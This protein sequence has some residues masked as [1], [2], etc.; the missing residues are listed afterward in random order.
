VEETLEGRAGEIK[1]YV[2]GLAVYR[3]GQDFD[4]IIDSTVRVEASRLRR[5]LANFYEDEGKHDAII[6]SVPKGG[7]VPSIE[8]HAPAEQSAPPERHRFR[9]GAIVAAGVLL[10]GA[11]VAWRLLSMSAER[12]IP[13]IKEVPLTSLPGTEMFASLSPDGEAA[14][15][16][17]TQDV[18]GESTSIEDPSARVFLVSVK[19]GSPRR[20]TKTDIGT[21][22]APAWS[23]SGDQ[24]ALLAGG[25]SEAF[26]YL[27]SVINGQERKILAV[28]N[29]SPETLSW[30]PDGR[31]IAYSRRETG[32]PYAVRTVSIPERTTRQLTTPPSSVLGDADPAFSPDGRWIVFVRRISDLDGDLYL[33]PAGGGEARRLTTLST[34][35]RGE[36]WMPDSNEIVFAAE[37]AGVYS[38]MRI[39]IDHRGV[40]SGPRPVADIGGYGIYPAVLR[41][42]GGATELT[43]ARIIKSTNIWRADKLTT[44]AKVEFSRIAPSTR[45]DYDPS[46]SPD[47]SSIAFASNR[48]GYF[49]IWVCIKDGSNPRQ[50]TSFGGRD[51]GSPRWS[52]DGRHIVFDAQPGN[53]PDIYVVESDG[54]PV[55]RITSQPSDDARPSWSGDGRW[56]YFRSD[57]GGKRQIWRIRYTGRAEP[58]EHAELVTTGTAHEAFESPDGAWVYFVRQP[59]SP[60]A[61]GWWGTEPELWRVPTRGGPEE[62]VLDG[63]R[64]G[65][66][67]LAES[68]IFF[69]EPDGK[70]SSRSST[71]VRVTQSNPAARVVVA[72]IDR[73][74]E[75]DST[76][77]AVSRDGHSFLLVFQARLDSDLFLVR[78]FR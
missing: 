28:P 45:T 73:Q 1:E 59:H 33:M 34:D 50:L 37:A 36:A 16:V 40:P 14:A 10:I 27:V 20:L 29:V 74:M 9:I 6:V 22:G 53:N 76:S 69:V 3:K 25:A 48:S 30:S 64:A 75:E 54:G 77:L 49:E 13:I 42:K 18:N 4:P 62:K 57:R 47:G 5:K 15:F 41:P 38:L 7:Y 17:W 61:K 26:L 2:I 11:G 60:L 70:S 19:G 8:I 56:I 31:L 32:R 39:R 52:P 58:A 55:Q 63:A 23:P 71:L 43:F 78:D 72:N 24:I 21:E 44:N 65:A 68:S 67:G 46:F 12:P 51:V 66:W 35:M